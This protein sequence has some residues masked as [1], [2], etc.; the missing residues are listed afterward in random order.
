MYTRR[1]GCEDRREVLARVV[2]AGEEERDAMVVPRRDDAGGEDAGAVRRGLGGLV[3]LS[4]QGE[5]PHAGV[6][7][8]QHVTVGRLDEQFVEGGLEHRRRVGED[9]PLR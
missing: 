8:V 4:A 6:V 3:D 5:H 7:V 9:L 1:S 2:A